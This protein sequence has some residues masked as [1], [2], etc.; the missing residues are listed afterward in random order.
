MGR[1]RDISKVFSTGTALATDTEV[2][3]SYL[4]L[5]SASTT[6]QTKATA[7]LTLLN[8]TSFTAQT[9]VSIND[10]FSATYDNYRIIINSNNSTVSA[11][12]NFLRMRVGG[13]DN[14]SSN[15]RWSG[16]YIFDNSATPTVNGQAS[17]GLGTSFY[18]GGSSSTAGF[19]G[20]IVLDL[21]NPFATKHTSYTSLAYS[22]DQ[23]GT[24]GGIDSQGG[25]MS[26]TTSYTG[27]T[28]VPNTG[29][30]TGTVSVYGYN[31]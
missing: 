17:N 2:S 11:Q 3:G 21:S 28:I 23:F 26:V 16:S 5:A 30:I 8:T 6:Y 25:V 20:A 15:Y 10:V 18:S 9:T 12:S 31:K 29:N 13:A 22:Y 1:A 24:R 7:G 14:S 27:F 4:T 19:T